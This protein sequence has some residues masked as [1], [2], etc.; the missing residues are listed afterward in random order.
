MK[1]YR[2]LVLPVVVISLYAAFLIIVRQS[3]PGSSDFVSYLSS[4]YGR[5]GYEIV[6]LG[7]MLEAIVVVNFFVP[8]AAAMGL[9]A[10]FARSGQLDLMVAILTAVGGAFIGYTLDFVLGFWGFSA[11]LEKT[12]FGRDMA[13]IRLG[14]ERSKIR[15]LSLG[16]IHPNIGSFGAL[17][18]GTLKMHFI[19]FLPIAAFSTIF[20][21]SLWGI[22]VFVL[23]EVFLIILT[24]Y[25]FLLILL[26]LSVWILKILFNKKD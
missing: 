12:S 23:G 25:A 9:G 5:Y 11:I 7:S 22:L 24:K 21:Y 13:K 3:L 20:W 1:K 14:L 2:S 10:V 18:A 6:F 17:A 26:A 16:F 4:V 19:K 8:G 15:T